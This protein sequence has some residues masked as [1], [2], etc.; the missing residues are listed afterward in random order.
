MPHRPEVTTAA[1]E[2]VDFLAGLL[3]LAL[4]ALVCWVTWMAFSAVSR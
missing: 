2:W 4:A 1:R 3:I